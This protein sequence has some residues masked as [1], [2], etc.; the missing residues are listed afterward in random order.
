MRKTFPFVILIVDRNIVFFND[1]HF[2]YKA[3]SDYHHRCYFL[4]SAQIIPYN[5]VMIKHE[6]FNYLASKNR[7]VQH[8]W[9]NTGYLMFAWWCISIFLIISDSD[10]A[11][12][13]LQYQSLSSSI[14]LFINLK[15]PCVLCG[16]PLDVQGWNSSS[17]RQPSC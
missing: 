3:N 16:W 9:Q 5:I 8:K 11:S 13:A 6:F 17:H 2:R 7:S 15:Y 14:T 12:N 4:G 1:A 10:F